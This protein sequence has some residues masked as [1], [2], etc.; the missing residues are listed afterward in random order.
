L[1]CSIVELEL[2]LIAKDDLITNKIGIPNRNKQSIYP[3]KNLSSKDYQKVLKSIKKYKKVLKKNFTLN[4]KYEKDHTISVYF[5]NNNILRIM[6]DM[7]GLLF[8][9]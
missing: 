4:N 9:N 2:Q 5:V 7:S 1:I 6:I 8:G 3:F